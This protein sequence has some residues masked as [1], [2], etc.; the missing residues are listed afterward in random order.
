MRVYY[1]KKT[2][3]FFFQEG[4]K[5]QDCVH[6]NFAWHNGK[7]LCC[8]L[9]RHFQCIDL[10]SLLHA[11]NWEWIEYRPLY[12]IRCFYWVV[13]YVTM[14]IASLRILANVDFSTLLKCLAWCKTSMEWGVVHNPMDCAQY[15][16]SQVVNLYT[17]VSRTK[18]F[19]GQAEHLVTFIPRFSYIQSSILF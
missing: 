7:S 12:T 16:S 3:F 10:K 19:A 11:N 4:G 6:H 13:M 14:S 8:F 17:G 18:P 1:L 15:S 2:R 9:W 5:R